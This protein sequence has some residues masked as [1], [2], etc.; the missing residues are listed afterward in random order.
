MDPSLSACRFWGKHR[1]R[2]GEPP[3]TPLRRGGT[4]PSGDYVLN[5][6]ENDVFEATQSHQ[7]YRF[8][9]A[10]LS[11]LPKYN[12]CE[13]YGVTEGAEKDLIRLEVG[14]IVAAAKSDNHFLF[15]GQDKL[16]NTDNSG[17]EDVANVADQLKCSLGIIRLDNA[18]VSLAH[19]NNEL[20]ETVWNF[21]H[22]RRRLM[23]RF[24]S[25]PT[26]VQGAEPK[27][28]ESAERNQYLYYALVDYITASIGRLTVRTATST[29]WNNQIL[30]ALASC[31]TKLKVL[32]YN[33][34]QH[35]QSSIDRSLGTIEET[36]REN[37]ER[38]ALQ[39]KLI[40]QTNSTPQDVD[41]SDT[42]IDATQRYHEEKTLFNKLVWSLMRRVL[43]DLLVPD[44]Q[45]SSANCFQLH[46]EIYKASMDSRR[47]ALY[48]D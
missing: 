38:E 47:R 39:L 27:L 35:A 3:A 11:G 15:D 22:A 40:T 30:S 44:N 17:F 36:K 32:S 5:I 20:E 42:R 2:Q 33:P 10:T 9:G 48:K 29:Y 37:Q 8:N 18:T 26:Q 45:P 34:S 4:V 1:S 41:A 7:K 43:Y 24:T 19:C 46:N 25:D 16:R 14:R 6:E 21:Q 13:E 12:N 23:G 28:L 31:A